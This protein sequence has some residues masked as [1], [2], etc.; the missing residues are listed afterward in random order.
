LKTALLAV[1]D[2]GHG[3][4]L[5]SIVVNRRKRERRNIMKKSIFQLLAG[6]ML[7]LSLLADG[8]IIPA[9]GIN[10]AVKYHHVTVTVQNQVAHTEV[11]QVFL[12]DTDKDS[13]E[14]IYVFP[15][16]EGATFTNFTMYVDGRPLEA[17]VLD[18]DSARNYYERI[19]ITNRD[20]ALLEYIDTNT[21]RARI[22]PMRAHGEKRVRISYDEILKYDNGLVRYLYP[23]STEK[24]SSRPLES[25]II[26]VNLSSPD[27]VKSIYSPSHTISTQKTDDYHA[28][29]LYEDENVIPNTDFLLYYS[30]STETIGMHLLTYRESGEDGFYLI[31]AAPRVEV[32]TENIIKKRML[33]VLDRSGS[34]SGEKIVQ[35]KDA[36]KFCVHHLNEGDLFNIIDFSSEVKRFKSSPVP[37]GSDTVSEALTYIEELDANGGTNIN[38]ALLTGLDN[39]R[40]DSLANMI[41]FLTDGQPTVGE[42]NETQILSNIRTANTQNSRIFVFGVGYDVNTH[43][44]DK[45]ADE[46][47]GLSVYV[48]PQEDIEVAISN[49]FAKISDPVLSGCEL[50]FGPIQVS[51]QFPK[52]VPDLFNGSQLMQL[53]KFLT[54]GSATI[55]LS[56]MAN[57][58]ARQFTC[59]ADFPAEDR[60]YDFI[61][62]LWA[63]RKVGELLNQ[64]RL[65][66]ENQELVDE[67]I[68]LAKRYG[69]IT[70][71]TS[72]LI[73][74]DAV[75]AGNFEGIGDK[76][77][78]VAFDN[79]VN[80]GN[81]R[82]TENTYGTSSNA[83]KYVG[84]KTFFMRDS[85]W[86]DAQYDSLAPTLKVDF[87]S[88]AYFQ[89]LS[90]IPELGNYFALGENVN[91]TSNGSNYRIMSKSGVTH[92]PDPAPSMF[93]LYQNT[94]NPFNPSTRIRFVLPRKAQVSLVVYNIL[95]Q[96]IRTLFEGIKTEGNYF[97]MWNGLDENG[98][99]AAG[100]IYFV[101]MKT[102]NEVHVKKMVLVR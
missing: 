50:D 25:V 45:L 95:G 10:M 13:I 99:M 8:F 58:Q 39:M 16:P 46:N 57:G 1:Q 102:E 90:D 86:M 15:L 52:T 26:R 78:N 81:W 62:R 85:V 83:V 4:C 82:N 36:L 101:M 97:V 89:L 14:A 93:Y 29:I 6:L 20:P 35:A 79:A 67:V 33:F 65:I 38:D 24:F 70:P 98:A 63:I 55:I 28:Q 73:M 9:P 84:N 100:S 23:L 41:I 92:N 91:V 51:E 44:L 68:V 75:P 77:G 22:Y 60:S 80:I 61:P 32:E 74:E 3:F 59:E 48:G 43:L 66:G 88:T 69:I 27:P 31:L 42:V 54:S 30:I 64:I 72:F 37:A 53:G 49:F 12:N 34:M 19:V 56:G 11:D 47:S 40:E 94:P 2:R 76:T 21:F 17:E 5:N 87:G 18:A 7:P 71:Y 96:K